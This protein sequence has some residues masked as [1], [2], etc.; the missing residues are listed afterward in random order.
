MSKPTKATRFIHA[1]ANRMRNS[2]ITIDIDSS[3][4]TV[5]I[6]CPGEDD[7]FM[8]GD[9]AE[10]FIEEVETMCK[11]FPS[12]DED[13]AALSLAEPYVECIWG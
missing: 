10:S 11:R 5:C 8:Q 3:F 9:D 13:T 7:I 4:S 1:A 12:L 6:S 2:D